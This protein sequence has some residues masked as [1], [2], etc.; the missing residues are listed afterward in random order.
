MNP[1]PVRFRKIILPKKM[2]HAIHQLINLNIRCQV[3]SLNEGVLYMYRNLIK[4]LN[5]TR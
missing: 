5:F 4:C 3:I 1:L 2:L